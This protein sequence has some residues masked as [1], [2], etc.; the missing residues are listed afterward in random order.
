MTDNPPAAVGRE[1][2]LKRLSCLQAVDTLARPVAAS[3]I[4]VAAGVR[5][6]RRPAERGV[7]F[8]LGSVQSIALTAVWIPVETLNE[9]KSRHACL[10]QT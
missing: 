9:H 6:W 4:P 8:D 1:E 3:G 10:S 5:L 7:A 2:H